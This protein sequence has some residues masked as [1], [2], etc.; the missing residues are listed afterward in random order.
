MNVEIPGGIQVPLGQ[1]VYNRYLTPSGNVLVLPS[2]ATMFM[3]FLHAETSGFIA[4]TPE[5]LSS[6]Q[7]MLA[8]LACRLRRCG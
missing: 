3:T 7:S 5:M 6:G 4:N 2:P 8:M 1:A